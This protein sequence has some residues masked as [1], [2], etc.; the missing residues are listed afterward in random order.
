MIQFKCD[1]IIKWSYDNSSSKSPV[2]S[3]GCSISSG[4]CQPLPMTMVEEGPTCPKQGHSNMGLGYF[5]EK[6]RSGD[7]GSGGGSS[8]SENGIMMK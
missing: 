5:E 7:G 2:G 8:S 4:H 6:R 3:G 1:I